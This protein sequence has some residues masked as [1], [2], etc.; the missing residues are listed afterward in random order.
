MR[1]L[2]RTV[3]YLAATIFAYGADAETKQINILKD[4][5]S[6]E[7]PTNWKVFEKDGTKLLGPSE[8]NAVE[9][10]YVE[11]FEDDPKVAVN[12]EHLKKFIETHTLSTEIKRLPN[13]RLLGHALVKEDSGAAAHRWNVGKVIGKRG[14]AVVLFA[15]H[16]ATTSPDLARQIL[17]V[18]KSVTFKSHK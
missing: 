6:L 10:A 7:I 11:L 3:F 13:G 1:F 4:A 17:Q 5:V 16:P 9:I 8:V 14:I 18:A 12:E 2:F 15:Y